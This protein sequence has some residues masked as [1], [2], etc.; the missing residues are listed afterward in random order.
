VFVKRLKE[1]MGSLEASTSYYVSSWSKYLN[2]STL[3]SVKYLLHVVLGPFSIFF[4]FCIKIEPD[5]QS[6]S[7]QESL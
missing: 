5:Y 7:N 6:N 2:S 1:V 3:L 4:I